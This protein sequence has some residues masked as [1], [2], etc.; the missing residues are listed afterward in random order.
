MKRALKIFKNI[1]L[2]DNPIYVILF[3]TS[4]C[5][6]KC[7]MCFNWKNTD[8]ASKI[9]ELS[10]DEFKKIF[11]NFSSIQHITVSGGEPFLRNDL[12]EILEYVS[13]NNDV[14]M[15][16]IPTNGILTDVI[17]K[18]T[19][20][21]LN[22]IK[23]DTH[24]R[25]GLSIEGVDE[26]HDDIVQVKGAFKNIQNT[27]RELKPLVR[28]YKNFN[29][30]IPICCSGFNKSHVIETA[31]YCNDF[32]DDCSIAL[33]LARGDVRDE[34][35]KQVTPKEYQDI[36][37][38]YNNIEGIKKKNKPLSLFYNTLF[39]MVNERVISVMNEKKMPER[40][41]A[42]SKLIVIQSNGD[43]LPCEYLG[44]VLGNFRDNNYDIGQILE[45]EENK[46]IERDIKKGKCY[47]TW[48]CAL[49]NNIVCNPKVYPKFLKEMVKEKLGK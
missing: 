3:V 37:N 20:K 38:N 47:C 49:S 44:K 34:L 24:L 45:K 15:I 14:Q 31:K 41:Y 17:V 7:K 4:K 32:F 2:T 9:E 11:E 10:L 46:Q 21:I 30:D 5:N 40:C 13:K 29:L 39:G 27:Y 1:F 6:A 23:K 18:Q 26:R 12:P 22:R 48:E 43:V 33:L 36:I 19:T 25:I 42:Y 8:N 35:S 28:K 16:T